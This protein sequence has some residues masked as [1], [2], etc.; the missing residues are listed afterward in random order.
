MPRLEGAFAL[1]IIFAGQHDLMT[2]AARQ[3]FVGYGAGEMFCLDALALAPLTQRICY[4]EE[5]DW[6]EVTSSGAGFRMLPV[7]L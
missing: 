1:V 3:S 7:T 2:G 4:L 5:G 6:A